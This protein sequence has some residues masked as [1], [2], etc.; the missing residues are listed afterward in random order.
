VAGVTE[1]DQLKIMRKSS[2]FL[3]FEV[4]SFELRMDIWYINSVNYCATDSKRKTS[5]QFL[6]EKTVL[7]NPFEQ[8]NLWYDE[9]LA[10]KITMP[11]AMTLATATK[12]G[13]PCL[14][15]VLLKQIDEHGLVF[16][17]N[18]RSRK[19]KEV[20]ENPVATLGFYWKEFERQIRVEGTITKVSREESEKYFQTRPRESQIGAHASNQSTP[21][22]N[23]EELDNAVKKIE[24]LYENK[25]VPCPEHW[26]GFCLKPD[27]FE[28][29]QGRE[30]RLHDRI[31]YRKIKEGSWK[32][33]RL[34]P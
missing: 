33:Q 6:D 11:M 9:I 18:Y 10:S 15:V 7:T 27:V 14:R 13:K 24:Q 32:I 8:F 29:W 25:T 23:R 4:F 31:E 5:M 16:F 26:G 12:D 28:F 2:E 20:A 21:I 34:A 19:S 1:S 30:G 17:T 22:G 3:H